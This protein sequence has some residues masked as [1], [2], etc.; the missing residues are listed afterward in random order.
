MRIYILAYMFMH[1]NEKKTFTKKPSGISL[2]VLTLIL[3][4]TLNLTLHF[5]QSAK[6]ITLTVT[7]IETLHFQIDNPNPNLAF[8][9]E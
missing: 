5:P 7:L 9:S 6:P 8:P 4:V 3:T 2:R 1:C